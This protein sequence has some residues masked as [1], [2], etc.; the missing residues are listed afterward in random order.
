MCENSSIR[1]NI[2]YLG[3]C[4]NKSNNKGEMSKI[5]FDTKSFCIYCSKV[6]PFYEP[7]IY[8]FDIEHHTFTFGK[9]IAASMAVKG[10]I[11]AQVQQLYLFMTPKM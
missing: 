1:K 9:F 8:L 5:L 3:Y 7:M 6:S 4:L 2:K 11:V 10:R